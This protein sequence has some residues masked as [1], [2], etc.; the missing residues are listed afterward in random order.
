MHMFCKAHN[1][2]ISL[3]TYSFSTTNA[4]SSLL[5]ATVYGNS[6]ILPISDPPSPPLPIQHLRP[7][8]EYL[9]K[10]K[11][12]YNVLNS[13]IAVG[14]GQPYRDT[15]HSAY[16]SL[17]TRDKTKISRG[18][19]HTPGRRDA[20]G[21]E[22]KKESWR[23]T[24]SL[25]IK[26]RYLGCQNVPQMGFGSVLKSGEQPDL[27]VAG[28]GTLL[29][30]RTWVYFLGACFTVLLFWDE[31]LSDAQCSGWA[32]AL[33]QK[34]ICK[35]ALWSKTS[36]HQRKLLRKKNL[37]SLILRKYSEMEN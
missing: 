9:N 29:T 6:E 12:N 32:S 31:R 27:C 15:Q 1:K 13:F 26:L 22:I 19:I 5:C 16:C 3:C 23:C 21:K 10:I 18:T 33:M 24:L 11:R 35:K 28:E 8:I 37:S 34:K 30:P 7:V 17:S 4:R 14:R 36:A 2:D 25:L 20:K